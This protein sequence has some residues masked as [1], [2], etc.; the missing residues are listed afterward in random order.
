M[1]DSVVSVGLMT[2]TTEFESVDT[3]YESPLY[4]EKTIQTLPILHKLVSEN[5]GILL[6]LFYFDCCNR[7]NVDTNVQEIPQPFLYLLKVK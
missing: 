1:K 5:S 4:L 2:S 7:N 6:I 3:S